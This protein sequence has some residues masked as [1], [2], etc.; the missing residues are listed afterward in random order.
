VSVDFED[1]APPSPV[2]TSQQCPIVECSLE[3]CFKAAIEA[4]IKNEHNVSVTSDSES[5]CSKGGFVQ[6]WIEDG[7]V[8]TQNSQSK[9]GGC[10]VDEWVVAFANITVRLFKC[11]ASDGCE[12]GRIMNNIRVCLNRSILRKRFGL[13]RIQFEKIVERKAGFEQWGCRF[14]IRYL[15]TAEKILPP[16]KQ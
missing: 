2:E 16:P 3:A 4:A 6:C 11:G 14:R 1:E 12:S 9:I 13:K 15:D 10:G 7:T 8:D 5:T